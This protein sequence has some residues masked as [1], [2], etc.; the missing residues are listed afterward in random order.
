[1][2]T[3]NLASWL[4][5]PLTG[6]FDGG[7]IPPE[8]EPQY[9]VAQARRKRGHYQEALRE[10]RAQLERFPHDFTGQ[11]LVAEIQAADLLDLQGA[12]ATVHRLCHQKGHAPKNIAYAWSTLAD[13][14][15]KYAQDVDSA[16]VSLEQIQV[17]LPDTEES[18]TWPE[19]ANRSESG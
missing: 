15:L 18:S 6:I 10:A 9:S 19:C 4:A 1:M 8:P 17:M 7:D 2:W 16:R 3:P 13:W 5:R 11:M 12:E 14:H